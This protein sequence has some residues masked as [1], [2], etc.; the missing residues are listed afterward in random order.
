MN[1]IAIVRAVPALLVASSLSAVFSAP[2]SAAED[3]EGVLGKLGSAQVV[4]SEIRRIV[5]LQGPDVKK[6]LASSL[7]DLDRAVRTE[8]VRKSL[9]NEAREKGW[10]KKSEVQFLM[11]RA[12]EQALMSAYLQSFAQPP[13]NYPPEDMVK[14]AYEANK[15]ALITPIQY[16]VSM[17]YI[18]SPQQADKSKSD[19]AAKK[20]SEISARLQKDPSLF[21][22]LAK[23]HSEEKTSA[24]KGGELGWVTERQVVA[25]ARAAIA[26]LEKGEVT[27]PLRGKSGWHIVKL[28]DKK[29]SRLRTL[30]EVRPALVAG[31]RL[32]K[33]QENEKAY[34]EN[35]LQKSTL[36]INEV[37]LSKTQDALAK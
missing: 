17:I 5:T 14:A 12:K 31:L 21:S 26:Q 6:Q 10:E 11:E 3:S 28:L 2:V 9:V 7:T 37:E 27:E 1:R 23:E 33:L 34:L 4:A 16:L 30:E 20:I 35:M 36:I 8:L 13:A 24:A 25:E 15:S 19:A 32:R 29:V 18:G 22:Q